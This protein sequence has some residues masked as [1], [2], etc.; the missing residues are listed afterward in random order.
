M[1]RIHIYNQYDFNGFFYFVLDCDVYY[2]VETQ[3]WVCQTQ[4][5]KLV[6]NDSSGV[7]RW[8]LI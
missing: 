5:I 8:N 1:G 4:T 7:K 2:N 3:S 6:V